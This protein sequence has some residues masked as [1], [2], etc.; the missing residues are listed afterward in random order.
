MI[1]VDVDSNHLEP[2]NAEVIVGAGCVACLKALRTSSFFH[3]DLASAHRRL[4]CRF[5]LDAKS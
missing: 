1:D 5:G 3:S 2:G 4:R